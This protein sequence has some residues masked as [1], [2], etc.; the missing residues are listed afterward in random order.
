[1]FG[2]FGKNFSKTVE[3][4]IGSKEEKKIYTG[5]KLKEVKQSGRQTL[6]RTDIDFNKREPW[7]GTVHRT[8]LERMKIGYAPLD[9]DGN[10]IELHHVGQKP[11]GPI[12]ELRHSEHRGAGNA[13]ILHKNNSKGS[14]FYGENNRKNWNKTKKQYWIDR[15]KAYEDSKKK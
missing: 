2:L 5:A 8:N 11:N 15:A 4:V 6:Q 9:R 13:G 10:P 7:E 14:E 12:A 3:K 1:M